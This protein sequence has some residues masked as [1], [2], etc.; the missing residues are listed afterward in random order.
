[1]RIARQLQH[2]LQTKGFFH[3]VERLGQVVYRFS[4]GRR[5]FARMSDALES[6]LSDVRMTFCA[7]A[8]LLAEHREAF[9]RLR[10]MGHDLA[11]HGFYHSRMDYLEKSVQAEILREGHRA[12]TEAGFEVNGFR[13]PYLNYNEDTIDVLQSS[14]YDWTSQEIVFWKNGIN[15]GIARLMSLYQASES[16]NRLSIP[17]PRGRV[18]EIPITAPDDEM[19]MERMRIRDPER[20]RDVW[21]EV[22]SRVYDRGELCHLLF[23]PERFTEIATALRAVSDKALQSSPSVW[24]ASLSEI[25]RWWRRRSEVRLKC[26]RQAG[27]GAWSVSG[28]LPEEATVLLNEPGLNDAKTLYKNYRVATPAEKVDRRSVFVC[29][30]DKKPCV[31]MSPDCPEE[32][33]DF[34]LTEGFCVENSERPDNQAFQIHADQVSGEFD[35]RR[36]L[37]QIES[38]PDPIFRLWRW[39][40]AARSTFTIS[41]D[42]DSITLVDFWHRVLHF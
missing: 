39:P 28:R 21:L 31:W 11:V 23:H 41:V 4:R 20:I 40:N 36:L 22:F 32:V 10:D 3:G 8:S 42:V 35:K 29:G 37:E 15:P 16:S 12:F 14:P 13:C 2:V 34:I 6:D 25:N 38:C 27:T 26:D 7:A 5:L 18:L 24:L 19:L 1:M 9:E 17:F 33:F 30:S